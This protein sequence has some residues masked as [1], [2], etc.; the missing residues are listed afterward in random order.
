MHL[1]MPIFQA[2]RW[3][4]AWDPVLRLHCIGLLRKGMQRLPIDI[5]CCGQPLRDLCCGR[6]CTKG[7][8]LAS[9]HVQ[10]GGP[11]EWTNIS[12]CPVCETFDVESMALQ[13]RGPH[14]PPQVPQHKPKVMVNCAIQ[15]VPMNLVVV[16]AR[17]FCHYL[18]AN[19]P[20]PNLPIELMAVIGPRVD[21][22]EHHCGNVDVVLGGGAV[23]QHLFRWIACL[24]TIKHHINHTSSTCTVL[25]AD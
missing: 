20:N 12:I 9:C 13:H 11:R 25:K 6:W 8:W 16:S 4:R 1:D 7:S 21:H 3:Q 18:T 2:F 24:L 15:S 19:S 17:L 14:L 10:S 5:L 22:Y 23:F